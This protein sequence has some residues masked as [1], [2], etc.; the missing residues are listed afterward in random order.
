MQPCIKVLV[1]SF[2]V[3]QNM[4]LGVPPHTHILAVSFDVLQIMMWGFPRAP[5]YEVLKIATKRIVF[6]SVV[7]WNVQ[8]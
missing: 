2:N 8:R 4:N 5:K 6:G 1:I 7:Y 3:L